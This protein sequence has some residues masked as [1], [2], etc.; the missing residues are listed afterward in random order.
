LRKEC[1]RRTRAAKADFFEEKFSRITNEADFWKIDRSLRKANPNLPPME[2]ADGRIVS[3]DGDKAELFASYYESCFNPANLPEPLLIIPE[4]RFHV[5]EF[6]VHSR[7]ASVRA[8]GI[9]WPEGIPNSIIKKLSTALAPSLTVLFNRCL[10]ECVFP[11]C[12]K[13]AHIIPIPKKASSRSA[14]DFRPIS[15]TS[16]FAKLFERIL[17]EFMSEYFT[18]GNYQFGFSKARS[19]ESCVTTVVSRIVSYLENS[20]C[21]KVAG[22]F[23][24]KK[25]A[26]D[27]VV[28][29]LLLAKLDCEFWMNH[30][31]IGMIKSFLSQRLQIVRVGEKLSTAGHVMSGVPQGTVLGPQLF[32]FFINSLQKAAFSHLAEIFLFADDSVLLKPIFRAPDYTKLQDD[33]CVVHDWC[34]DNYISLNAEKCKV[35]QFSYANVETHMPGIVL[36]G[37]EL[38]RVAETRYL[39]VVLQSNPCVWNS[40]CKNVLKRCRSVFYCFRNY[41]RKYSPDSVTLLVH[42]C[43]IRAIL[44][45]CSNVVLPNAYFRQQFER[46][47]K[48]IVR[49]YLHNY[50]ISYELA[51]LRCNLESLW[52]R[53]A[54]NCVVNLVKYDLCN[55]YIFPCFFVA[56]CL[57]RARRRGRGDGGR[58]L[59]PVQNYPGEVFPKPFI[60]Y[61]PSFKKSYFY[62]ATCNY[63]AL[64][65]I[66][67]LDT[68][69]FRDLRRVLSLFDYNNH[70]LFT[71]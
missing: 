68:Y 39:G 46:L 43:V 56:G 62:R 44:D 23:F 66:I 54:A 35:M 65:R 6:S 40:H 26:F 42:K 17:L 25:K 71:P 19:C 20:K 36:M 55:H 49:S 37:K 18:P 8:K 67:D 14:N 70:G 1:F 61:S 69:G 51:L 24:D 29:N 12:W 13:V 47:Q 22:V 16:T 11:S 5:E 33:V 4:N 64:R 45:Y 38:E 48:L 2:A 58:D 7:L 53:R 10:D 60:T 9:S 50:T 31:L 32:L 57:L 3:E 30:R 63:N 28:H 15:L 59:V 52:S 41:Y 34:V 27:S 21:C